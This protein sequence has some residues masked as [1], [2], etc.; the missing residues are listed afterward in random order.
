MVTDVKETSF[1]APCYS[2]F[3]SRMNHPVQA[4]RSSTILKPLGIW[5]H[6]SDNMKISSVDGAHGENGHR[7]DPIT[8]T[9]GIAVVF[10][11]D[12]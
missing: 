10:S 6:F 11:G 4:F 3:F 2:D 12:T 1:P 5:G 9:R 8:L 7:I